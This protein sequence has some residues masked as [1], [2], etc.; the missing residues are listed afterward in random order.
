MQMMQR[1]LLT[2]GAFSSESHS[3]IILGQLAVK[4]LSGVRAIQ[5]CKGAMIGKVEHGFPRAGRHQCTDPGDLAFGGRIKPSPNLRCLEG[6]IRKDTI[7]RTWT[8]SNE[9]RSTPF[10]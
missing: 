4:Q 10:K 6:S 2:S 8:N 9:S 3:S 7:T 5:M 1:F